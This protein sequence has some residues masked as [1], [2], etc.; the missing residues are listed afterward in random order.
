MPRSKMDDEAIGHSLAK[1]DGWSLVDG[2][3]YK[4]FVF[5]DFVDAFTFMTRA[6]YAIE[7]LDHHPEWLNVY[8]KLHVYLT[9]HDAGG[10]TELD[11]RLAQT[12][13]SL[14]TRPSGA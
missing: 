4:L 12:L 9:T 1:L 2:K 8:N 11:F 5:R 3:L 14:D 6:S 13:D 7:K 10:I